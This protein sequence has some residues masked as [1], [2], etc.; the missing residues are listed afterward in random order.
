MIPLSFPYLFPLFSVYFP[1]LSKWGFQILEIGPT[2]GG[3]CSK[4][5]VRVLVR[6]IIEVLGKGGPGEYVLY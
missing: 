4:R 5:W 1:Y 6:F 3:E 2:V